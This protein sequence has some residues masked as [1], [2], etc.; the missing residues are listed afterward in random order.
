[1]RLFSF[2]L[3]LP[4]LGREPPR[5]LVCGD[6]YLHNPRGSNNKLSEVSNNVQNDNRLFDSQNNA[7]AGD[8]DDENHN[9][10]ETVPGAMEGMMQY[11]RGSELWIEW[12][13]QHGCGSDLGAERQPNVVCTVILQYMCESDNRKIGETL[14]GNGRSGDISRGVIRDGYL[15]GNQNNA[16]GDEI[17]TPY[18]KSRQMAAALGEDVTKASDATTSRR[19][20]STDA[21][22]TKEVYKYGQHEPLDYY[23]DCRARERNRGLYAANRNVQDTKGATATR[24]N[25]NGERHGLECAEERDYYPYWHPS[26][27][28]DIAIFTSE[29]RCDYFQEHSQNVEGKHYCRSTSSTDDFGTGVSECSKANNEFACAAMTSAGGQWLGCAW[30]EFPSWNE[31]PGHYS[32][33]EEE[34]PECYGAYKT[35]DNH[36]GNYGSAGAGGGFQSKINGQASHYVWEIPDHLP[37]DEKC[38]FRIRYNMTNLDFVRLDPANEETVSE[39]YY[40]QVDSSF[41]D[42]RAVVKNNAR[43]NALNLPRVQSGA[44]TCKDVTFTAENQRRVVL[45]PGGPEGYERYYGCDPITNVE[46]TILNNYQLEL[47]KE[48]TPFSAA[49]VTLRCC[50][51]NVNRILTVNANE[52]QLGRTFQD[53]SHAFVIRERPEEISGSARIVNYNVRGRRGNIVQVYPAVEYDFVPPDLEITEGDFLHF[54]WAMSDAN[55]NNAGNGRAGTDRANLVQVGTINVAEAGR[56]GALVFSAAEHLGPSTKLSDVGKHTLFCDYEDAEGRERED[57]LSKIVRFAYLGQTLCTDRN[58]DQAGRNCAQLNSASPYFNYAAPIEMRETGT[59]FIKSTRN[60]DFS[61][62]SQKA[63]ITV[64]PYLTPLAWFAIVL[65]GVCAL[66]VPIFFLLLVRFQTM[67]PGSDWS[68]NRFRVNCCVRRAL[69]GS[70]EAFTKWL[71][72][73]RGMLVAQHEQFQRSKSG[74]AADAAQMSL[75]TDEVK[76]LLG[77][78]KAALGQA[79]AAAE[80]KDGERLV[81][82]ALE[83]Q[84]MTASVLRLSDSLAPDVMIVEPNGGA[85][86]TNQALMHELEAIKNKMNANE[87]HNKKEFDRVGKMLGD[88]LEELMFQYQGEDGSEKKD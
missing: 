68:A 31:L 25:N 4:F 81:E 76:A 62:R 9:Y 36:N 19:S 13:Q 42:D 52:N 88:I 85:N 72:E 41:N 40:D 84:A 34:A 82:K 3:H 44:P 48:P 18:P 53:R 1:M 21:T 69:G 5:L 32:E 70:E 66:A 47:R 60:D 20:S 37:R 24:Q 50:E 22:L 17:D 74:V 14:N 56:R 59:F 38:V 11:Y 43:S 77:E 55:A 67:N 28:H 83:V 78:I 87:E 54:Q 39:D 71:E 6:M 75:M 45:S 51:T 58:N 26:P 29:K 57:C 79:R 12:T 64:R 23:L 63:R 49:P 16:G 7:R 61:N 27:W 86:V 2:F 65:A 8:P 35:R 15:R 10:D 30:T 46:Q 80:S 33:G 73:R